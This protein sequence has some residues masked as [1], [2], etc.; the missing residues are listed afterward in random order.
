MEKHGKTATNGTNC[1]VIRPQETIGKTY[2]HAKA[3]YITILQPHSTPMS[4]M[5]LIT[6]ETQQNC[7][8]AGITRDLNGFDLWMHWPHISAIL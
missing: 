2:P 5:Q 7:N 8:I 3:P 4:P 6:T 1:I